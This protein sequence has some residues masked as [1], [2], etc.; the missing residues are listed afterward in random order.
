M[1][2]GMCGHFCEEEPTT[3]CSAGVDSRHVGC[4]RKPTPQVSGRLIMCAL[5]KLCLLACLGLSLSV[6]MDSYKQGEAFNKCIT[7]ADWEGKELGDDITLS[8]RDSNGCC[9]TDIVFGEAY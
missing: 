3:V 4:P 1:I 7:I 5:K 6:K 8:D 2:F 9:P